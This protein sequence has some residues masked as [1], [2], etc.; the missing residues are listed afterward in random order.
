MKGYEGLSALSVLHMLLFVS[1]L[2]Q[3]TYN[4]SV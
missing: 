1:S 2:C 3:D 4:T